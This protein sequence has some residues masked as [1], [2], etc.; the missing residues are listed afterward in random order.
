MS[1]DWYHAGKF[2]GISGYFFSWYY[3]LVFFLIIS[4][5]FLTWYYQVDFS[6]DIIMHVIW[7][8]LQSM[9]LYEGVFQ[10]RRLHA[11]AWTSMKL[12]FF[13]A[14]QPPAAASQY[15]YYRYVTQNLNIYRHFHFLFEI[16]RA[17]ILDCKILKGRKKGSFCSCMHGS[18]S[19]VT[20]SWNFMHVFVIMYEML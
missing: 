20:K 12:S 4:G 7:Y 10:L 17:L 11:N 9:N 15:Y 16:N 5:T 6:Y 2:L 14:L 3:R 1:S 13:K 19:F 18:A 8:Y